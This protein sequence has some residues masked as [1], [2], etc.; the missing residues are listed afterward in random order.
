MREGLNAASS[1]SCFLK[2]SVSGWF[3]PLEVIHALYVSGVKTYFQLS[4]PTLQDKYISV[5]LYLTHHTMAQKKPWGQ[6]E[7]GRDVLWKR[8]SYFVFPITWSRTA[9]F[10]FFIPCWAF[11]PEQDLLYVR[12]LLLPILCISTELE[13]RFG[14]ELTH[15]FLPTERLDTM[16][17]LV[18]CAMTTI[19]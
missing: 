16:C 9:F 7:R 2:K 8:C 1:C 4:M 13:L 6:G 15:C 12:L 11:L 14:W 10:F 17:Q 3:H 19:R 5:I 18:D